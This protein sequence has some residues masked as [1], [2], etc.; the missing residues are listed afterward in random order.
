MVELFRFH[1][2]ADG[3]RRL[4]AQLSDYAGRSDVIVLGLPRGGLV[5]AHE[6]AI[7]LKAPL[8]VFPVRKLGVPG[9]PELAMGAVAGGGIEVLNR[10]VLAELALS[11]AAVREVAA[12]ERLELERREALYRGNRPAPVVRGRVVILVDDGL[13]TGSTM[14]AA[15]LALRQ[16]EPARLVAAVPV[17]AR[18]A[19]EQLAAIADQVVC[20]MMPEPFRAVGLWYE[21]F[22]Q[23]TDEEVRRRLLAHQS[24]V[25]ASQESHDC[26]PIGAFDAPDER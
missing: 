16:Q 6:V 14:Q 1:D 24:A 7:A 19:C 26:E 11:N 5:V 22:D 20:I 13:A 4:A 21:D 18:E 10:E 25:E 2:R 17:G 15:L 23:T 12:R 8:D 3:G 9:H